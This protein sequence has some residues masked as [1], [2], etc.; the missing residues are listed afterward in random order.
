[1]STNVVERKQVVKDG[2]KFRVD[3]VSDNQSSPWEDEWELIEVRGRRDKAPHHRKV[4]NSSFVVDMRKKV[5]QAKK[6][7]WRPPED[8]LQRNLKGRNPTAGTLAMLAVESTFKRACQCGDYW[9]YV[10]VVVT[11]LDKDGVSTDIDQ[12]CW[13]FESDYEEGLQEAEKDLISEILADLKGATCITTVLKDS[14]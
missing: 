14:D 12:S 2:Y 3:V 5:K 9:S 7:G 4:P 11:L 1:M 10:G 8:F 6:D 13:G